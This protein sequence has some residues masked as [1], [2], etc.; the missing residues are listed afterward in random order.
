VTEPGITLTFASGARVDLFDE[1][2]AW[3]RDELVRGE[4]T[5]PKR[6]AGTV[7]DRALGAIDEDTEPS[8]ADMTPANV[9]ELA[10]ALR[11]M[12]DHDSDRFIGSPLLMH[13]RDL[14]FIE[15]ERGREERMSRGNRPTGS[16][17]HRR[18]DH[19]WPTRDQDFRITA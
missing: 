7:V 9:V 5:S 2:A 11:G 19:G 17:A 8:P 14:L 10:W 12:L 4:Y 16:A 3:L 13:L 1:E 15:P 6:D 18:I